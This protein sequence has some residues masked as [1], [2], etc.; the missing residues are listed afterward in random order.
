MGV[1]M[2]GM[3]NRCVVTG[4]MFWKEVNEMKMGKLDKKKWLI[5]FEKVKRFVKKNG[6]LPRTRI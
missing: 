3:R 5:S 4:I 1:C 2:F 6:R